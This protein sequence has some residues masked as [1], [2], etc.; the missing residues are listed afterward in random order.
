MGNPNDPTH[1]PASILGPSLRF[2]GELHADEDLL[3]RGHIEGSITHSQ[4]LTICR[5][6]HVIADIQGQVIAVEGTVEGDLSASTSVAIMETANLTGDVRSPSVSVVEGAN[7]NGNVIM[8]SSKAAP[9]RSYRQSDG[10][11]AGAAADPA[12]NGG[13]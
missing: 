13:R 10:R 7:F 11:P 12:R 1:E 4:R 9:A 2:K 8:D 3:I 5:E 6:G